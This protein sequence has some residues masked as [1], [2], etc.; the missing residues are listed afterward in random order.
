MEECG[1]VTATREGKQ[2]IYTLEPEPLNSIREGWLAGF[3]EMQ[4]DSL[5]ALRERAESD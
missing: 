3:A 1:V 2:Q 4:T 5:K